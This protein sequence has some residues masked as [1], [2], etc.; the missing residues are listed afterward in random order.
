[1]IR[2]AFL[3]DEGDLAVLEVRDR[4]ELEKMLIREVLWYREVLR[5]AEYYLATSNSIDEAFDKF[6][7]LEAIL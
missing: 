4:T 5:K 3:H 2:P 7:D 6:E 1:M